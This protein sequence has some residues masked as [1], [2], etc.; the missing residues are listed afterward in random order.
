MGAGPRV[1][2]G[3]VDVSVRCRERAPRGPPVG[4]GPGVPGVKSSAGPPGPG[5]RRRRPR[6]ARAEPPSLFFP[7]PFFIFF[8]LSS[9]PFWGCSFSWEAK[10]KEKRR[11]K[12]ENEVQRE[13][14]LGIEPRIFCYPL[15]NP[16]CR[17]HSVGRRLIRLA[18]R[19]IFPG[20][21][22]IVVIRVRPGNIFVQLGAP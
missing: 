3:R 18:T 16:S 2:L 9:P 20:M 12:K 10:E 14:T 15:S 5:A 19:T 13:S 22:L 21:T 11:R 7:P 6:A 1:P 8:S 4:A 17:D